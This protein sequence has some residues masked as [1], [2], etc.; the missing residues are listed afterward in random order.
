[1]ADFSSTGMDWSNL[2]GTSNWWDS[3][4]SGD[5]SNLFSNLTS[6]PSYTNVTG[7]G[8]TTDWS[9]LSNL[10][11]TALNYL[12]TQGGSTALGGLLGYLGARN[13]PSSTTTTSEPWLAQQPFLLDAFQGAAS[14]AKGNDQTTKANANYSSVLNGPTV[15]PML[16]TDNPY[17]KKAIDNANA[18]VNR[19]ML[20]AMNAANRASG[21]YGN[22]G[23]ADT[24]GKA[25]TD[26]YSKNATDMRMADY[27]TQQGLYQ[28]AV[29]NT[30]GFTT[31]ANNWASQP[32]ANYAAT[33]RG[34]YGSSNT[35]PL[36]S[37]PYS[38]ALGGAMAGYTLGK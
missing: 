32:A 6:D 21:S 18:D 23:I 7:D 35:T 28:N 2:G 29:N 27:G 11:N 1:M 20:P 15:N 13:A 37:N 38:S 5:Y 26:A 22:S 25:L 14:A 24:Y 31:N 9:W 4:G 3:A 19:A 33:I 10:G 30:L 8:G 16:G 17:L 36:Y 34:N 12:G